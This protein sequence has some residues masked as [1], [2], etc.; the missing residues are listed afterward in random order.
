MTT[1][2]DEDN[3]FAAAAADA[4]ER[5]EKSRLPNWLYLLGDIGAVVALL[6]LWA[7]MHLA[8]RIKR[9]REDG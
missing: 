1:T 3:P 4:A 2:P 7:L 5:R 9:R 6:P 8:Q